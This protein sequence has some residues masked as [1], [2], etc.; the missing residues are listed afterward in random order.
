MP[1]NVSLRPDLQP[2]LA[3]G[4]IAY[5]Q[6]F[7]NTANPV[8]LFST[9]WVVPVGPPEDDGQVIFLFNGIQNGTM[10]Y[11]PVLQW[12]VSLAGGE[13]H[14]TVASWYADGP[15][16]PAFHT[17]LVPVAAGQTLIGLMQLTGS[18]PFGFS[19][20]CEFQG[21]PNTKLPITNVNEL[22]DCVQTLEAYGVQQCSDYPDSLRTVFSAI[23]I[24]TGLVAPALNWIPV[25]GAT[26]CKQKAIV[27]SNQNPGGE[28]DV[29]YRDWSG[30]REVP[31]DHG[32]TDV[33]DCAAVFQNRLFLFGIDNDNHRHFMKNTADGTNWTP[34]QEIPS[35]HGTTEVADCAVVFQN[36]L[37]LFGVDKDN[38]RHFMKSTADGAN[39]TPWQEVPPDHGTSEVADCA[40]VFNGRLFLIGVDNDNHRHFIKSSA[41]GASW[42]PWQEV[43]PDHGTTSVGDCAAV[44][45]NQLFLFGI[46]KDTHQHFVKSTAD[47]ANWTPWTKVGGN[48]KTTISDYAVVFQGQLIVFGIDEDNHRHFSN[49]FVP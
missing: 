48:G 39:W 49:V 43:P 47:G 4:W 22:R 9:T 37:F 28:V 29:Y 18:G 35:D 21:I 15:G 12:G 19:Y 25:N 10:I 38:H 41:D 14:W 8:S 44:F 16:G 31:P 27:V 17:D 46:D 7:N 24:R 33:A 20:T 6:W 5:A 11:Q 2:A 36:R 40:V 34:W 42:T 23:N 32:T 3:S 45:Q 1:D 26:D 30:W 13:N